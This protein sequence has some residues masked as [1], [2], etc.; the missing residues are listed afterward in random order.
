[1]AGVDKQLELS[2]YIISR[3]LTVNAGTRYIHHC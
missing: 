2:E 1:M 3:L